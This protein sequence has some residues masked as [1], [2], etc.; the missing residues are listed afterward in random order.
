MSFLLILCRLD[1]R[2]YAVKKIKLQPGGG[3][4]SYARILREVATLSRLQH[5]NVVRYFQ[6]KTTTST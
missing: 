1:G 4:G 3:S 2:K 6:V 5:P